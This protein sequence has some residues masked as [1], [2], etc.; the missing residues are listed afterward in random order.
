V[1]CKAGYRRAKLAN[2]PIDG[3]RSAGQHGA[4]LNMS[5]WSAAEVKSVSLPTE[6]IA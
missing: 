3:C 4:A 5:I 1:T 6:S 2:A